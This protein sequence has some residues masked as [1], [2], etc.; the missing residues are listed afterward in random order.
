MKNLQS[1]I[2]DL[3]KVVTDNMAFEE[4]RA[5][6]QNTYKTIKEDLNLFLGIYD[7]EIDSWSVE[8]SLSVNSDMMTIMSTKK[9]F[10]RICAYIEEQNEK[11]DKANQR[12]EI[13]LKLRQSTSV[14]VSVL[15]K[16]ITL[17][18]LYMDD[19]S[20]ETKGIVH[21]LNSCN[22]HPMEF[23][24]ILSICDLFVSL[25]NDGLLDNDKLPKEF[26]ES[27]NNMLNSKEFL[28]T[29]SIE[30]DYYEEFLY[31]MNQPY[32]ILFL[33]ERNDSRWME[34][35]DGFVDYFQKILILIA[36][37]HY[38]AFRNIEIESDV[39]V[40]FKPIGIFN[41][42]QLWREWYGILSDSGVFNKKYLEFFEFITL[43]CNV[44]G[45]NDYYQLGGNKTKIR[46]FLYKLRKNHVFDDGW[47]NEVLKE[48]NLDNAQMSKSE[49]GDDFKGK[50]G[51]HNMLSR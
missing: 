12:R 13:Y 29:R 44:N 35:A 50:F 21:K 26:F 23:N 4:K 46:Y 36:I 22:T 18:V 45:L 24:T 49:P 11:S 40:K 41:N 6:L 30:C 16:A 20:E 2:N 51:K 48:L 10:K 34:N 37:K 25:H 43:M 32:C 14:M 31:L 33:K 15:Q 38:S 9:V 5:V 3:R 7:E 17:N 39:V 19:F 8:D 47:Y 42:E 28:A 1:I 27:Y